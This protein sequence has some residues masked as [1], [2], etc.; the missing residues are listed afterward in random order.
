MNNMNYEERTKKLLFF[1]LNQK[2]LYLGTSRSTPPKRG[3]GGVTIRTNPNCVVV[4]VVVWGRTAAV[5]GA[6]RR[7]R[8]LLLDLIKLVSSE[9]YRR[10]VTVGAWLMMI[11]RVHDDHLPHHPHLW[12]H[13]LN[14]VDSIIVFLI[15]S[16]VTN[17][18][19]IIF[20]FSCCSAFPN[21]Q[22]Q[23]MVVIRF[24]TLCSSRMI[25]RRSAE[26][27]NF[28]MIISLKIERQKRKNK[29]KIRKTEVE[30][31]INIYIYICR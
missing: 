27:N 16:H 29:H 22:F 9:V 14:W 30:F 10:I 1:F 7:R 28:V 3:F 23:I 19:T 5:I 17:F 26:W 24:L 21:A 31:M 15:T 2:K 20:I 25:T 11:L 13:P 18:V 6:Q 12:R 8:V 4:V